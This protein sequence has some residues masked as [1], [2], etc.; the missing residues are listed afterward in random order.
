MTGGTVLAHLAA[1]N[2]LF[3][4]TG[5]AAR[6]CVAVLLASRVA[7]RAGH[8]RVCAEER[9]VGQTM[10]EG[11][12]CQV[13]DVAVATEMLAVAASTGARAR[14]GAPTVKALPPALILA[15]R[16][17]TVEA[18]RV[19]A[20]LV[21]KR[22]AATTV[23][24]YVG[25]SLDDGT[26]H[27]E[28]L[29]IDGPR[30]AGEPECH[31]GTD[32]DRHESASQGHNASVEVDCH[33]VNRGSQEQKCTERQVENVP[34]AEYLLI[35]VQPAD[36]ADRSDVLPDCTAQIDASCARVH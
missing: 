36:P 12:G 4:M 10:I 3:A 33:D 35:D 9:G 25:V 8:P 24:L 30:S 23:A 26:R 27:H 11:L 7:L 2:V 20:S 18:E 28:L 1:V 29:D 19:L 5:Q 16:F 34:E 31:S 15:D 6:L 13:E 32:R 17:V 21:E 22:M 14:H